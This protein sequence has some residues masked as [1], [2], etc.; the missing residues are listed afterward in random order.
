MA[1][2]FDEAK[3]NDRRELWWIYSPRNGVAWAGLRIATF[4]WIRAEQG[5]T[6]PFCI[7][8][9]EVGDRIG[10]RDWALLEQHEQWFKVKQIEPPTA[11]D[12]MSA[13]MTEGVL[14]L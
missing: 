12:V 13:A 14:Q 9:N 10:M 1:D 2:P 11:I 7:I 5:T 3:E 4:I 8:H 6:V